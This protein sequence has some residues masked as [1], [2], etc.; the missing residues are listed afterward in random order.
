MFNKL[1]LYFRRFKTGFRNW[2]KFHVFSSKESDLIAYG[3]ARVILEYQ[4]PG[5]LPDTLVIAVDQDDVA[6]LEWKNLL[7]SHPLF[8][9]QAHDSDGSLSVIKLYKKEN[10]PEPR[11]SNETNSIYTK[12]QQEP[13]M[14][15][16]MDRP[17]DP[18]RFFN[19]DSDE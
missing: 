10:Q 3:L 6:F 17:N 12:L 9:E 19:P 7:L 1:K 13:L 4:H 5:K 16:S 14:F 8:G 11:V 18:L 15:P 2:R